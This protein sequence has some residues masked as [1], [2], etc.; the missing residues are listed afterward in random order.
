M[1]ERYRIQTKMS[2]SEEEVEAVEEQNEL[3]KSKSNSKKKGPCAKK[4]RVNDTGDTHFEI[5]QTYF[6]RDENGKIK[7]NVVD[8]KSSVSRWQ[9]YHLKRHFEAKHPTL[10]G[11]LFP[12]EMSTEKKREIEMCEL[13]NHAVELVTV[14]AYPFSIL[15]T[16]GLKGILKKPL[17]DLAKNGFKVTINRHMIVEKVQKICGAIKEKIKSEFKD[18]L[19]SI[20]FDICKKK[21]FAV[22]GVSAVTMKDGDPIVRSLGM[23]HL[24]ERHRGPYLADVVETLLNEYSTSLKQ[25]ISA[26]TDKAKNMNNTV[27]HLGVNARNEQ[28]GDDNI[29][30]NGNA[31]EYGEYLDDFPYSSDDASDDENLADENFIELANELNND[32]RYIEIVKELTNELYR[33]NNFLSLIHQV[34]CC[35]HK[36]QL[37]V[38]G[39]VQQSNAIFIIDQVR[40]MTKLLRT[41]VVNVK[42]RKLAPDCVLPPQHVETRWN[43]DFEMVNF[44]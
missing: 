31:E 9:T 17:D 14:N 1:I 27:R 8:C 29:E 40:E 38:N 33:R 26:T 19:F 30:Q 12:S 4:I 18:K 41:T 15:D 43:S 37:A 23:I 2:N 35:S 39:A 22:L 25:V 44:I 21:T 36:V 3:R 16:S 13:S 11:E 10:L 32:G 6:K 42:F 34:D 24:T 20:M 28:R 5:L 7:C